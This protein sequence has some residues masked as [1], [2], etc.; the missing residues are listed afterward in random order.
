MMVAA[1]ALSGALSCAQPDPKPSGDVAAD[2]EAITALR[3]R[4]MTL[5]GSGNVE[6]MLAVLTDDVVFMPPD[7]PAITGK[8]AARSWLQSM[9]EQVKIEGT[10]TSASDLTIN[11]DW[12]FERVAFA[13]K[14]TPTGGGAAIEDQIERLLGAG[15]GTGIEIGLERH[16]GIEHGAADCA[17][18]VAHDRQR[19]PRAIG[20]A[21]EVDLLAAEG[22][23]QVVDIGGVLA[24]GIGGEVDTRGAEPVPAGE[25]GGGARL[26]GL[27]FG[28][29][30]IAPRLLVHVKFGTVERWLRMAGT[31]LIDQHQVTVG[32]EAAATG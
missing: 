25:C 30:W 2:R 16:G 27:G 5:F 10:Y 26:L 29:T 9:V 11:G 18:E 13:L 20:N 4:E 17:G 14:L 12:A 15:E 1:A 7:E 3:E 6:D 28:D 31:A 19:E 23:A 22:E 24:A 32:D 8:D 21:V